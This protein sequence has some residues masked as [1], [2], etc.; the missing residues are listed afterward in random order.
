M[1]DGDLLFLNSLNSTPVSH[2]EM[3]LMPRSGLNGVFSH[4]FAAG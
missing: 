3:V 1:D 2:S 4:K